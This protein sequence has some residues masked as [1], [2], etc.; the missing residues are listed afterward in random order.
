MTELEK[1]VRRAHRRLG[2]QRFLGVLGWCCL[3]TLLVAL[4]LVAVDKYYPI[5]LALS[6]WATEAWGWGDWIE[7]RMAEAAAGDATGPFGMSLTQALGL[8]FA[9]LMVTLAIALGALVA[10]VYTLLTRREPLGAAIEIDRRF[11]LKER[12][13]STLSLTP[14]DRESE[15][16]RALVKDAVRRVQRVDV[17]SRFGLAP[18]KRILLPLIPG[19]LALLVGFFQPMAGSPAQAKAE[20]LKARQQ[21]KMSTK[22]LRDK[23]VQRRKKAQDKGLKDAERLF[24]KLEQGTRDITSG[25]T[26]RKK[27]LAKLNDL[28]RE[29]QDRRSRL[30]ADKIKKE[31]D[32]LKNIDRGPANKFAKAMRQGDFKQAAEE[33]EAIKKQLAGSDLDEKQKQ[34]LARQL[35]QMQ[36]KLQELAEAHQ[37]AQRDLQN[38]IAKLQQAGRLGEA[39]KLEEQLNKLLQQAPQMKQLDDMANKLGQCAKCLRNGQL[40]DAGEALN[41]LQANLQQQLDEME[42]LNEA[43]EQLRMARNQMNC[44]MCGGA[45][46]KACQGPPGVGMGAGRGKG[47]RPEAEEDTATYDSQVRQKIGQGAAVVTDLVDGPNVRGDP[48]AEIQQEFESARR[49]TT[50]PL[51]GRR[52]PR[53][54]QDHVREYFDR[55]REGE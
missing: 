48:K 20:A 38:Q 54:H 19:L 2:F 17:A 15:A 52:I 7:V 16:G 41:Q 27:A 50:D 35:E 32:Q 10:I 5:S 34:E 21:V 6:S 36:Q 8:L 46:C 47:P 30:G 14:E 22:T 39:S 4:A 33:L 44:P 25:K 24:K 42:M 40:A 9:G 43:L 3:A 55:F 12:V 18:R 13:A 49:S 45:G 53:K 1:Q 28:S 29:L 23:L 26:E 31:L 37:N 51:T 11:G